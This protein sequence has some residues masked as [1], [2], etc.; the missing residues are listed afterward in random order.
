MADEMR[1]GRNLRS[2]VAAL[3]LCGVIQQGMGQGETT[4]TESNAEGSS[5]LYVGTYTG[6]GS[7]GIY[8]FR[9]DHNTAELKNEGLAS[10][11]KNP[12]FLALSP[13]KK[14]LY[15]VN[16]I[17]DF[18]G[19]KAG[20]ASSFRIGDDGDLELVDQVPSGGLGPCY[21]S[22]T[23]DGAAILVANY[24]SGDAAIIPTIGDGGLQQTP[25]DVAHHQGKSVVPKRQDAPHAHCMLPD[26]SGK[27]AVAV[28]LGIDQVIAYR[29]D[30]GTMD[31][32]TPVVNRTHEGAGPRHI[33]FHPN[34]KHAYVANELDSTITTFNWDA[35]TGRLTEVESQSTLPGDVKDVENYPAEVLVHPNGRYVYLS[36]RGHNSVATF[37]V[38]G[39]TGKLKPVG[40]ES[41]RGDFPRGMELHP[42]GR[43]LV[44]ANQNSDNIVVYRI[45]DASGKPQF[46]TE[47][48]GINKPAGLQFLE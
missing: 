23:P 3:L 11:I 9:L 5:I 40:H 29:L 45:D 25:S 20:G 37:E 8:Q 7:R 18:E 12:S 35:Q 42:S 43:F 39:T 31:T 32:S 4:M 16:E 13:D 2:S 27:W 17:S 15:C 1:T 33:A 24:G 30:K 44:A 26:P 46:A 19:K 28:D 47:V 36:N 21:V 6:E 48:K 41:T 10:E 38:D 34:G 14:Y 22:T